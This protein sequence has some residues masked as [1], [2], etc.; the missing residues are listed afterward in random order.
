[1]I[2]GASSSAEPLTVLLPFD[3]VAQGLAQEQNLI[4]I[5]KLLVYICTQVWESDRHCLDQVKLPD[6]LQDLRAIAPTSEQLQSRLDT[7]VH[8]LSKAAEYTLVS[9]VIMTRVESLYP[10]TG[11]HPDMGV[12]RRLADEDIYEAI[13]QRLTKNVSGD[14]VK[15]LLLLAY[16]NTWVTDST[17]L[18]QI[19]LI[20][21]IR[22]LHGL[23]PSLVNL[24][25]VLDSVVNTLNKRAEYTLA[26]HEISNAF[27]V[28]YPEVITENRNGAIAEEVTARLLPPAPSQA[29]DL[30]DLF[31]L[32]LEIMRYTNP[33]RAKIVLF[34]LLHQ[35]FTNPAEQESMVKNYT[36]DDLLRVMLQT[37]KLS[38][39]EVQ[40][41]AAAKKLED[42]EECVQAAH[43]ILGA[44]KPFYA[45]L[46][47]HF[48]AEI[49]EDATA[50]RT[51][52]SDDS[53]GLAIANPIHNQILAH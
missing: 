12:R 22:D 27:Q 19:N 26:S 23:T 24:Q 36:L 11:M 43:V 48:G 9:N 39:V 5:K 30:S 46:P 33:Y 8:S 38:E 3:E 51:D 14:R 47:S 44:V 40:L 4:R 37:Y 42:S 2:L 32:R 50:R 41:L 6:L 21:L 28:L 10:D 13:A 17:Q 18:A 15:K 53:T 35:P 20:D 34:S 1:M 25:A 49:A 7:A 16:K 31:D 45:Q 52:G 29:P